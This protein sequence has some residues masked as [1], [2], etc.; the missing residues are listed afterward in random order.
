MDAS[1]VEAPWLSQASEADAAQ[2]RALADPLRRR[3]LERLVA[4][5]ASAGDLARRLG[6]PRVNVTHHLG[7]LA[8]AGLV[9]QRQRQAAVKPQ[10]LT[11]L[12]RYFDLAL[13]VAAIGGVDAI[14]PVANVTHP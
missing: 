11:R 13:T 1:P 10:A 6:L 2:F 3:I 9:D 4:G 7:V 8:A 14:S 12:R 5:P